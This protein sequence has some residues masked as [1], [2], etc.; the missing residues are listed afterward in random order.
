METH[1]RFRQLTVR[2]GARTVLAEINLE[3]PR[4]EI[5]AI[6]GPANAGKSTLLKCINRTVDFAPS[7]RV[8][9]EVLVDG[10]DVRLCATSTSCGGRSAWSFRCRWDCR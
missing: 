2:Y 8:S 3:I 5:F 1:I 7:A 10:R 4:R 9:G 6:I